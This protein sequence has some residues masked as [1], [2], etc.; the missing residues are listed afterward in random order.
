MLVG[1]E[2]KKEM[3]E[4]GIRLASGSI[5]V[6]ATYIQQLPFLIDQIK[7]VMKGVPTMTIPSSFSRQ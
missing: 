5:H 7:N 3:I 2:I 4:M 1:K 6:F